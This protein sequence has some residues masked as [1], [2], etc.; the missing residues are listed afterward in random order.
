MHARAEPPR[1]VNPRVG[2]SELLEELDPVPAADFAHV[3][4][5]GVPVI[6]ELLESAGVAEDELGSAFGAGD[7]FVGESARQVHELS[8]TDLEHI[9][10]AGHGVASAE[11]VERLVHAEV[12][13]QGNSIAGRSLAVDEGEVTAGLCGTGEQVATGRWDDPR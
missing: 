5:T 4:V 3:G 12:A 11:N 2:A 1:I 7:D 9:F 8:G 6:E 10:P 13:M